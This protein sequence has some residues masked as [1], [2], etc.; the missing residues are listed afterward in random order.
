MTR[1]MGAI[2]TADQLMFVLAVDGV[3]CNPDPISFKLPAGKTRAAALEA[4]RQDL[5]EFLR[6]H[7]TDR[8]ALAE[9]A[10]PAGRSTATYQ[11]LLSRMS[12]ELV[13]EFAASAAGIELERLSRSKIKSNLGL[14]GK[15][16]TSE[17]AKAH[18]GSPLAPYWDRK[19]DVAAMAALSLS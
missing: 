10:P 19:R 18:I 11:S 15:G 7:Q 17:L 13:L 16:T 9:A 4:G 3:L 2:G 12:V 8:V 1:I 14:S 6:R 5:V